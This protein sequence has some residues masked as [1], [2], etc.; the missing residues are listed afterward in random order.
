MNSIEVLLIS[1]LDP[2]IPTNPKYLMGGENTYTRTLLKYPPKNIRFIHFEDAIN[3]N[4]IKFHWLQNV[5]L[6]LQK[7]RILPLG[8]RALFIVINRDF[9]LVYVHAIPVKLFGYKIPLVIS[10]SS[11]NSVFLRYYAKWSE[12]RIWIT[13]NLKRILYKLFNV[14]DGEVNYEMIKNKFVFSLWA[15]KIKQSMN[16]SGWQVIYPG[17]PTLRIIKRNFK[18]EKLKLLFVGV[19]FERKGGKILLSAFR[20][21]AVKYSGLSLTILGTLPKEIKIGMQENINQSDF[22]SYKELCKCYHSHD[23]LVHIPPK[24]EGYGMTV[25]EAMS[26]GMIPVVSNI[27]ALPEFVENNKSGLVIKPGSEEELVKAIEKLINNVQLRKKLSRGAR[28]RFKKSFSVKI[29]R[30]KIVGLFRKAI[31]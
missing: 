19:W 14:L 18:Q 8:P 15:R 21:L 7:L 5:F 25:P 17:L 3:N 22:V 1:P 16:S 2:D 23:V 24:I 30:K 28:E 13:Q 29:F 26:Y 10:D 11:S 31:K 20:K 6:W 12:E 9:D 4:W 27:C